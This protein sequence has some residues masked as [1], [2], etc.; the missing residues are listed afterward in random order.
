MEKKKKIKKN[1]QESSTTQK[2][3][4]CRKAVHIA[5]ETCIYRLSNVVPQFINCIV[6]P[7]N[8]G[9]N[10]YLCRDIE[11]S[12]AIEPVVFVP[13]SVV[14]SHFSVATFS[15]GLFLICVVTYFADVA[16]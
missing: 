6:D 12:V 7:Q 9:S 10:W 3:W 14:A 15:L 4:S 5:L 1:V 2:S 8:S 16:T 11:S 13:S